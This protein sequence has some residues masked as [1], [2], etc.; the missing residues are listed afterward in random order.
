MRW[1][2]T[3]PN[4]PPGIQIV[5]LI[6]KSD[7]VPVQTSACSNSLQEKEVYERKMN[8][9]YTMQGVSCPAEWVVA[10]L[11]FGIPNRYVLDFTGKRRC[12]NL[13]VKQ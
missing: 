6:E 8:L 3:C 1:H 5:K 9:D 4:C 7:R 13:Q 11:Q 2:K 12:M 10:N